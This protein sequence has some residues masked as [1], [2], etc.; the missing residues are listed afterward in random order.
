V[1]RA[2]FFRDARRD[3]AGPLEGLRVLEATTTWAGPMCGCVLADMG[4]DVIK[5]EL[6]GGEVARRVPP[7]LPRSD[8][9]V[10]L[11][12][13]AVNRNKRSLA[14]DLRRD[15]GRAIFLRLAGRSDVVVENF[16]A[17]TME[18]WGV[19]YEHVRAVNPRVVY[20]SITGWGQYGPL[21]DRVGYDPMAQ[22]AS[23]WFAMN[24]DP[25]GPP[26][27]S[28]TFL[29]D[30]LG[31][32][33]GALAALGALRHRDRT[34]E[35]QH[36][37]VSLLDAILFQS[38]GY[39]TL[40][41]LGL[42]PPRLGSQFQVAAPANVYRARDGWVVAGVLL[43]SH[44]RVLARVIGRAELGEHP[45]YATPGPRIARRAEVDRL[46]ADWVAPRTVREV[47][48]R[49]AEEGIPAAPVQTYEQAAGDPH[50][51]E[52]DMLQEAEIASGARIPLTG[53]A[54]KFSRT[55][56]RVRSAAPALG[57]HTAQVLGELGFGAEEI[58]RLRAA[59]VVEVAPGPGVQSRA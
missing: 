49:F 32:L 21:S 29:A 34:G 59:G 36:V 14:L 11:M 48:E 24:G 9:P 46:L 38:N 56:T 58:A 1:E 4:A 20:V 55:P 39:L 16:R 13:E 37:D 53:P 44:W 23:G 6:P 10:A 19:G 27:K 52:R 42:N 43:D 35:G 22:A 18:K 50:V 57:A 3:L 40:G 5:V 28:P 15:E 30:D 41:A 7:F 8:P 31:G 45:D 26:V 17:G 2:H 12:H 33:H 51:K 25:A 47:V 54:A